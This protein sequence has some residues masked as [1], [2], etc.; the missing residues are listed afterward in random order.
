M[1]RSAAFAVFAISFVLGSGPLGRAD[2][3]T[4]VEHN[5][6]FHWYNHGIYLP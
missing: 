5:A 3:E 6:E 4:F 1:G 2:A